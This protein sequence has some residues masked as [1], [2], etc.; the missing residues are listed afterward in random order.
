M[1][2]VLV[3]RKNNAYLTFAPVV[4]ERGLPAFFLTAS[5]GSVIGVK[6]RSRRYK[7]RRMLLLDL[8]KRMLLKRHK[9]LPE[10]MRF[11]VVRVHYPFKVFINSLKKRSSAE[12]TK[13][14]KDQRYPLFVERIH[15]IIFKFHKRQIK[16]RHPLIAVEFFNSSFR[17]ASET[18]FF[19]PFK[20]TNQNKM[21]S[22]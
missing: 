7:K 5:A 12:K 11:L 16:H 1:R 13:V 3:C 18:R 22:F 8:P 6:G 2:I 15:R 17:N 20:K 4:V 19:R 10:R 9:M 21:L 14:P